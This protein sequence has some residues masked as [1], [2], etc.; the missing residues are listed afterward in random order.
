MGNQTVSEFR[1]NALVA[2][3]VGVGQSS[4]VG[5]ARENLCDRVSTRA[6]IGRPRYRAG[7]LDRS[8]ARTPSRGIARH[9]KAFGPGRRHRSGQQSRKSAPRQKIHQLGEK[10]LADVHGRLLGKA[11]NSAQPSSNR[12]H[13]F[14]A[15]SSCQ[16]RPFQNAPYRQP[17]TSGNRSSRGHCCSH[18]QRW[19]NL[20]AAATTLARPGMG[21]D[22]WQTNT[23][24]A[25]NSAFGSY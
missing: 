2:R 25:L 18:W 1:V 5:P 14:L 23:F 7:S 20:Y 4:I 11:P 16:I 15:A 13:A 8:V 3:L 22:H 17:D 10:R 6:P 12:H 24:S 9:N 21:A 19:P